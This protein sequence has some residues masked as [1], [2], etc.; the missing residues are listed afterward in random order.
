MPDR[1]HPKTILP[2]D[3]GASTGMDIGRSQI[4][5]N[6]RDGMDLWAVHNYGNPHADR[7][8]R[9]ERT[10]KDGVHNLDYEAQ[11]RAYEA[12]GGAKS[13]RGGR[14]GGAPGSSVPGDSSASD[15]GD[16]DW[17]DAA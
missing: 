5:D 3:T 16:S 14:T 7:L 10:H 2:A 17:S 1:Q 9:D 12:Q 15:Y 4:Q 6:A 11:E 13:F 8:A